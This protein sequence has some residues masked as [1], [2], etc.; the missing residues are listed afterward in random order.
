MRLSQDIDII[1]K[2]YG[3]LKIGGLRLWNPS[4]RFLRKELNSNNKQKQQTHKQT[5]TRGITGIWTSFKKGT[6]EHAT[7]G[8][9]T[10]Y[11]TCLQEHDD[12]THDTYR[13][14]FWFGNRGS[15]GAV[16]SSNFGSSFLP[17]MT[18][19][20]GIASQITLQ[21]RT[22]LCKFYSTVSLITAVATEL[23][24]PMHTWTRNTILQD[25]QGPYMLHISWFRN[26]ERL[27]NDHVSKYY[28]NIYKP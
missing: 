5:N 3:Q 9:Y 22:L 28:P 8:H 14:W 10:G 13:V 6:P 21:T 18:A 15:K 11:L 17:A 7:N 4:P 26:L 12:H 19:R 20:E 25:T 2:N 1:S 16:D 23:L 24:C 27:I